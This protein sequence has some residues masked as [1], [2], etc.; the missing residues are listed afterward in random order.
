M[1]YMTRTVGFHLTAMESIFS[2]RRQSR[3][4]CAHFIGICSARTSGHLTYSRRVADTPC[5]PRRG[6]PFPLL[7][8]PPPS[9][10]APHDVVHARHGT[11]H[12]E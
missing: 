3:N 8:S 4:A 2:T 7:L 12:T 9:R 10:S 1:A 11:R 6:H 5:H